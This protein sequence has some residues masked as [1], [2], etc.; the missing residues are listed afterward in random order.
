MNWGESVGINAD[1]LRHRYR[2]M[3]TEELIE[4]QWRKAELTDAAIQ[5]LEEEI[6]S[7][8]IS[9][10]VRDEV[11]SRLKESLPQF[12]NEYKVDIEKSLKIKWLKLW[13]YFIL[14][15]LCVIHFY[16]IITISNLLSSIINAIFIIVYLVIIFGLHHRRIVAWRI[17][18]IVLFIQYFN[19][20][21]YAVSSKTYYE[22]LLGIESNFTQNFIKQIPTALIFAA[23]WLLPQ[24]IYWKKRKGLFV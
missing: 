14:P 15:L 17:N 5:I 11:L 1:D 21:F 24:Y 7:R 10:E 16:S 9:D 4:L 12:D 6:K 23:I 13:N 8:A 19:G 20:V 22:R 2:N 3:E 18:L